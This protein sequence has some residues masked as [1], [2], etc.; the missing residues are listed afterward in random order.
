M[1]DAILVL[2][3]KLNDQ[4]Q[5]V[6]SARVMVQ[7]AVELYK[8]GT[9]P[10]V[11]FSGRWY[12]KLDPQPIT[13]AQAMANYA[14][15]LGLPESAI[16]LE[17][18]SDSTLANIYFTKKILKKN[19]WKKIVLINFYPFAERALLTTKKIL[20]SAYLVELDLINFDLPEMYKDKWI[21]EEEEKL[22]IMKEFYK[23]FKEGDDESIYQGHLEYLERYLANSRE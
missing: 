23:K 3:K 14:I 6:E 22:P 9:A 11:I 16:V 13:E 7:R 21:R 20:G 12:F 10:R 18:Q 2:G 1:Y 5:L 4:N 15:S 19:D 17:E 8:K